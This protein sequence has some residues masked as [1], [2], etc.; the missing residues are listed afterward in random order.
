MYRFDFLNNNTTIDL[1]FHNEFVNIF[2]CHGFAG[3]VVKFL[4]LKYKW[5]WNLS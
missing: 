5:F 2:L 4:F 1:F 3:G